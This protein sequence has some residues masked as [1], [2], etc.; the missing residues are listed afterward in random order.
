MGKK[1]EQV[2][3]MF[4]GIA[5]R[6]DFLNHFLSMRID[7]IWRRKAV[8]ELRGRHLGEVLDV[9]TGTG[10]LALTLHKRLRPK[11][12]TGID[13]SENMLA[14]GRKKVSNKGLSQQIDLLYGDSEEIPFADDKFDAV[15]V[16]FGVR[17]FEDLDKGLCEMLRVLK[18][19]GKVV[20]LEFSTPRNKIFRSL[21]HFYSFNILPFAG[22]LIS[23]D[24]KAYQYLP[25]S[26]K[27]FP[28]GTDFGKR[29]ERC[30]YTNVHI[31]P[32]S[33]GIACIYTGIKSKKNIVDM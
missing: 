12:I 33:F 3:D 26:V 5:W 6:Y 32:L 27:A 29:M 31:R 9:A 8:N 15:M 4:D 10:D 2:A 20:I 7:K 25:E 22:R 19:D 23:K 17:N 13:I 28:Y 14:H 30:G 16:A 21:Y 1:K 18:S 24:K 11:H